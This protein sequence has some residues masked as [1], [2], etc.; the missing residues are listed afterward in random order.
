MDQI[1]PSGLTL[2]VES[3]QEFQV[4]EIGLDGQETYAKLVY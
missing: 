4:Q 1:E 2:S 3:L